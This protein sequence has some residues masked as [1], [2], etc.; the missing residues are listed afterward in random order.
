MKI[1]NLLGKNHQSWVCAQLDNPTVPWFFAETTANY[2]DDALPFHSSFSHLVYKKEQ[3][4]VSHEYYDALMPILLTA[5]DQQ[6]TV[7][8]ELLRIRIGLITRVPHEI[9]HAPHKDDTVPHITGLY[10][11][12]QT[13][14]D[15]VVYNET[16]PSSQY[17]IKERITPLINSWHQ[18]DG[19]HY[20]S[21]SA[22]TQHEKRIVITYNYT[23]W[24]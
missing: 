23:V 18:F 14:G 24:E 19:A 16:T 10:Y 12:N 1:Q 13:D 8:K 17:T 7:L 4:I 15:T 3:G 20:H 9:I 5:V 22:P 6:N 2:D 21:S 11:A